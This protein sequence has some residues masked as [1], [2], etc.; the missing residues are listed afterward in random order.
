MV[1]GE[2]SGDLHGA[3]LIQAL[4]ACDPEAEFRGWGGDLMKAEGMYVLRHYRDTTVMGFAEV[5]RKLPEILKN[6]SRCKKDLAAYRPDAIILID[7]PGFNLRVAAYAQRLGIKTYYYIS[8][9]VWAWKANRV[10]AIKRRVNRLFVTLPFEKAF[11]E[12]YDYA[13]DFVGHPLLDAIENRKPISPRGFTARNRLGDN[14]LIALLPG[15]RRQ[16]IDTILPLLLSVVGDFPNHQF[17]IAAAPGQKPE[18]YERFLQPR[19]AVVADQ[20]Y[21]LLSVS[22]AALVTSGTA[23]LEAALF[24]VPE[25]VCYKTSWFSY[26]I[27]KRLVKLK[28]ISLVN[29]ILEQAV[30]KELIQGELTKKNIRAQLQKI[31]Q[32]PKRARMQNAF[33][34]LRR[35]LGGRGASMRTAR[36]IQADLD[37]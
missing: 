11:Y 17:V 36:L 12:R 5:L 13:V 30:V 9:Q 3:H 8:P 26:A 25:V 27:G 14:P 24:D 18:L 16:E 20:T 4:R 32:Q 28:Y 34:E 31:L 37:S 23:T 35:K 29:L 22:Q 10:H 21:D 1:A 19:V 6:V 33:A 2:A 7:Y 15:S